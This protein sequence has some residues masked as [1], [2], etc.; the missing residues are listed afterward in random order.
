[1]VITTIKHF[2]TMKNITLPLII[3][4]L[5]AFS[6]N[7]GS[8]PDITLKY[9]DNISLT[10]E[11]TIAAYQELDRFYPEARLTEVGQTDIGKPLHLFMISADRDFD[12]VSIRKKGKCI[13]LINNGIH[14]G[15]PEGID[16][17]VEFAMNLLKDR[18]GKGKILENSVIAIIPV[19]NIGGALDRSPYYR[20]N[21]DGPVEKGRRRNAKNMDLNRD[22]AKQ[23]TK[24]AVSFARLFT[25]LNPDL[26]LDTHTTNG[27]DHQYVITLIPTLHSKMEGN[28]G[29]FFKEK[30]LPEL[31]RRMDQE[32]GYPMIPY[33]MTM[34]RGDIRSG[35]TGYNDDP[36]Y[37]T[38][39][40]S[41]FNCFSF[42]TE[43]L[44]YAPFPDRVRSVVAFLEHMTSFASENSG[45]IRRLKDEADRK[46][47][48]QT[49]FV[50]SWRLD[51]SYRENIEF[52]GYEYVQDESPFTG[53]RTGTYD[54]N[55]PWVDTIP[56]FTRYLPVE[57]VTKP[58]AYIIPQAWE[59]VGLKLLDN[60]IT[61]HRLT[62]DM[63]LDVEAYYIDNAESSP[64]TTQGH[65]VNSN[66]KVRKETITMNYYRGD[67]VVFP[68]QHGNR[69]IIEM[70]EPHAPASWFA[71]NF[72][73]AVLESHDFYSVWGFE[74]HFMELLDQDPQLRQQFEAKKDGDPEFAADPVAQ[75]EYLYQVAPVHEI[76]KW[77]R[78]YPVTR[79]T[80]T[81]NL[82]IEKVEAE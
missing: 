55:Q 74:S 69:Y 25:T 82:K 39:Y 80:N 38:G 26:F 75:L 31:Y 24:N 76:E 61:L 21:Q 78:L 12:P 62:E 11:E 47:A 37:S 42:M 14:P 3:T 23:D 15:E 28:M 73:D 32:S 46:I 67:L 65:H 45:E 64:R 58:G 7:G 51:P 36:F 4:A 1:M 17:S 30:M 57:K 8:E 79:V 41:L 54:H 35:I 66:V 9:D 72:F 53:R 70:L 20:M 56:Y 49:E 5:L 40:T 52:R 27:S 44:V 77:N 18:D 22:F 2:I 13:I 10:W 68:N 50:L 63:V 59:D 16:A 60:N 71:W 48:E 81:E 19:Y 33:V 43:N 6:C 34:N 29:R